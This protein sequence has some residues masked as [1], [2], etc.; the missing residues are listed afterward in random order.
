MALTYLWV[1]AIVVGH[2]LALCGLIYGLQHGVHP[3][4][5]KAVGYHLLRLDSRRRSLKRPPA[6]TELTADS[7]SY[8]VPLDR[9]IRLS[10]NQVSLVEAVLA[11]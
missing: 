3:I 5:L 4:S 6:G 1:P 8:T 2:L 10:D 7:T 9:T 11:S